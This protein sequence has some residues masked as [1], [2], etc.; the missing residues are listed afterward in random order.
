MIMAMEIIITMIIKKYLLILLFIL[1]SCGDS[2]FLNKEVSSDGIR[3]VESINE[4]LFFKNTEISIKT[5][6]KRG[7][8]IGDESKMLILLFD[9]NGLSTSTDLDFK[10]MLWMPTMGHGSFPVSVKKIGDGVYEANEVFFTM[11]GHWDIHFQLYEN[12]TMN[13]EIIWG[14]EL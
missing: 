2:P 3:G 6:W 13:E 11:P 5:F 7:P 14:L 10:V 4:E 1:S 9:K 8:L 12:N